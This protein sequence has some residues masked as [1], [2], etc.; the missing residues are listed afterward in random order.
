[1]SDFPKVLCSLLKC[2]AICYIILPNCTSEIKSY[3]DLY[4]WLSSRH[5]KNADSN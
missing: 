3:I 5:L 2:L 1:M 4:I